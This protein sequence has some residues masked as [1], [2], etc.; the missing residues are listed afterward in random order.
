[1]RAHRSV[2][3]EFLSQE[4]ATTLCLVE[5]KVDVLSATLV[6]ELMGADFDYMCL[7]SVGASGG[8][9]VAWS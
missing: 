1:M 9:I 7:P 4:R 8:V 3:R 5:T 6:S 2:V